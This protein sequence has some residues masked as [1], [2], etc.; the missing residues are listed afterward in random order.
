MTQSNQNPKAQ[1]S[2]TPGMFDPLLCDWCGQP[3]AVTCNDPYN[4]D[5][6]NTILEMD[7]CAKCYQDRSDW[8]RVKPIISGSKPMVD[9]SKM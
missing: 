1:D 6:N 8:K 4:E 7:L 5:V 3:G 2:T 9:A